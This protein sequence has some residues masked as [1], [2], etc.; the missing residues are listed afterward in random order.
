M[1]PAALA[2]LA[3][4]VALAG[5]GG[6]TST[7]T[8]SSAIPHSVADRLAGQ[9]EAIVWITQAD[10]AYGGP[11]VGAGAHLYLDD[12]PGHRQPL[13]PSAADLARWV[14]RGLP[15][16]APDPLYLRRPDVAE[17]GLRK[18]VL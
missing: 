1:R 17:P 15:T 16:T 2:C 13:L 5:C 10:A 14:A 11:S 8:G 12:F 9:S 4:V 18:S 3:F 6:S 7:Q